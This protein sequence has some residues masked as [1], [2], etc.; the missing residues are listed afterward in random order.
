MT[1]RFLHRPNNPLASRSL[2]GQLPSLQGSLWLRFA[3]FTVEPFEPDAGN[4]AEG[5]DRWSCV[6]EDDDHTIFPKKPS[7]LR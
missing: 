7:D 2:P 3:V 1:G 5:S 6:A 4:A